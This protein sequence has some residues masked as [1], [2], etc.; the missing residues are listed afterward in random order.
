MMAKIKLGS[1]ETL[2]SKALVD[3]EANHEEFNSIIRE[4]QG[5]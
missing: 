4:K 2:V 3:I 5:Y 1:I